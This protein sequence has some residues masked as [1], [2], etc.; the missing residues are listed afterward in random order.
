MTFNL[1]IV[2]YLELSALWLEDGEVDLFERPDC[3][4][5]AETLTQGGI[6]IEPGHAEQPVL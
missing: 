2:A 1:A 3:G 5:C 6:Q 4:M